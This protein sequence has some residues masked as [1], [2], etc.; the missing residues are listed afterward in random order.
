MDGLAVASIGMAIGRRTETEVP[1]SVET[2]GI[3]VDVDE[4]VDIAVGV[5]ETVDIAVEVE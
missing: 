5:D 3:T 4:T 1:V 2:I